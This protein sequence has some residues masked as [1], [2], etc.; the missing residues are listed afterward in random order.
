MLVARGFKIGTVTERASTAPPGTVIEPEGL[1]LALEGSAVPLV[2]AAGGTPA[3]A[4][5]VFRVVGT[6]RLDRVKRSYV[7]VRITATQPVAARATLIRAG[8]KRV[9]TWRLKVRAGASIVKL[10]LPRLVRRPGRYRVAFVATAP[11]QTARRTVVVDIVRPGRRPALRRGP[12]SV[13]L[14]GSPTARGGVVRPLARGQTR[15]VKAD[16][17]AAFVVT[18]SRARNVEVVVVDVDRFGLALVRDLRVVFPMV[19]IVA[20]TDKP[21]LLVRAIKTGATIALPRSTPDAQLVR[22]VRRLATR[23]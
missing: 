3:Q 2:V 17:D 16:A 21:R 19:R 10:Q 13:V 23:R 12:V 6:R 1:A 20:L 4:K 11:G 15:A 5:L 8:G 14:T 22:I 7:G 9:Y 18:A